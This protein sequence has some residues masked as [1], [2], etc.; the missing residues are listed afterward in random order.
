MK[1]LTREQKNEHG[2]LKKE[3]AD[4]KEYLENALSEYNSLMQDA[5]S[6]VSRAQ[7]E[8]NTVVAS[9]NEFREGIAEEIQGKLD[10]MSETN[11]QYQSTSDWLDSWS[12]DLNEVSLDEPEEYEDLDFDTDEFDNLPLERE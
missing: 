10:D 2:R 12:Q 8:L 1:K 11:A 6:K 3:L 4:S 9:C 5:W 7:E